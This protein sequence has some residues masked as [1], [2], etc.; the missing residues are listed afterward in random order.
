MHGPGIRLRFLFEQPLQQNNFVS[1]VD[2]KLSKIE[3]LYVGTKRIY[4]Q[5]LNKSSTKTMSIRSE[6]DNAK[7]MFTYKHL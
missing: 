3:C 1:G 7:V 2:F 5:K 4:L 6:W